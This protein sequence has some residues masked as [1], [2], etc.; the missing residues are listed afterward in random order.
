[1]MDHDRKEKGSWAARRLPEGCHSF[2][3]FEDESLKEGEVMLQNPT[4]QP[5]VTVWGQDRIIGYQF[6][7]EWRRKD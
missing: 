2:M 5:H 6:M 4:Y 3:T 7:R 1:M